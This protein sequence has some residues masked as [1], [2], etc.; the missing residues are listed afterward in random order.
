MRKVQREKGDLVNTQVR[1]YAQIP[2]CAQIP[3][4]VQLPALFQPRV[5]LQP[6]THLHRSQAPCPAMIPIIP[7][8][9]QEADHFHKS[10]TISKN[11]NEVAVFDLSAPSYLDDRKSSILEGSLSINSSHLILILSTHPSLFQQP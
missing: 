2:I 1:T 3:A 10:S 8:L 9:S 4:F 11:G 7:V 5:T 6:G